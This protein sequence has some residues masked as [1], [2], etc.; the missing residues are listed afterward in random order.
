[1][2]TTVKKILK[3]CAGLVLLLPLAAL[4]AAPDC[5]PIKILPN[6]SLPQATVGDA[7]AASLSATEG[8]NPIAA[9]AFSVSRGVLPAGLSLSA[10]GVFSGAP[11][12]AGNT[13]VRFT[14][15]DTANGCSGQRTYVLH[16]V[17]LNHPPS[18]TKG[19]DQTAL[20]D[21]GAQTVTGWATAISDGDGGT[22]TLT[23][24]VTNNTNPGLFSA[25]P[26]VNA[27]GDL[28]YTPAPNA[29]GAATITLVLQDDGGT[30]N[31]GMD[32]SAPQTFTINVTAVNDAPSFTKGADQTVAENAPA[33]TI[34]NWAT[35]ISPGPA[36]ESGQSVSFQV[37]N[38]NNALFSLQ[39]AITPSGTLSFT[40]APNVSGSATVSVTLKDDGGT[41]N[42]G[43]DTSAAQ[44]F[45]ITVTPVNHAPSFTKGADQTVLEDAGGQTV[46]GWAT[47]ISDGDGG[48][49]TLT[50]NVTGNTNPGLFSAAPAVSA[51]GVLTYTPAAN[52]NGSATLTLV[53]Q[54]NGGTANGGVDTSAP[55]TFVINVT[56]VNDAPSFTAGP[57]QS[58]NEDAGARIVSNWATALS[59]GPADESA[60]TVSLQITGNSNPG[61]FAV[62]PAIDAAGTLTY[63]P[64]ANANGVA[65]V[66][67]VAKDNGGT[68]NGG[69][70]TSAPHT[71]VITVIPVNDAP[72]FSKGA[73]LT[74]ELD[75]AGPRTVTGWATAISPGPPDEAGQAVDFIVSNDNN[76]AFAV[77]PAIAANGTLTFTPAVQTAA[78]SKTANVTVQIHDNG[79]TANGGVD[80]SAAQ[81]FVIT[82]THANVAPTLGT[83]TI[84]YSTLGNTQLHVAGALRPGVANII[85]T[86]SI[87]AKSSPADSD[88]PSP[89]STVA[90]PSGSSANGGN[91]TI[92]TDGSF[93]YVPPVGF[94]GTD[95]FAFQ[96]TDGQDSV[97]GTVS[98]S[99]GSKVW[100]V[101]DLIDPDNPAGGDGRSSNAFE[102]LSA[103][104]SASAANDIIFVFRGNTGSTPLSA[105][106][107]LKNGQKLWGEGIGLTVAPFGTLVA[108]GSKP[109]VVTTGADTVSVAAT[110]GPMQNVEIRG[111][112]LA[113][114]GGT[115]NAVDVTASG[116]NAVG[117]TISDN[118]ISG[119]ALEGI[120]L[121]DGS[122]GTFVVSVANNTV[123]ST[124]NGIDARTSVAGANLQLAIDNNSNITAGSSGIVVDG[125]GGGSATITSFAGNTVHGNTVATGIAV[126]AARFDATPGGGFQTVSGG[127]TT[128][129]SAGN[130]VGGAGMV[131]TNVSGDISFTDLDV[132]AGG[133]D[134][135]QA[136]SSGTFN[137]GVGT[138]LQI[139][140]APNVGTIEA[141]G[142]AA[143]N[144]NTVTTDI[145]LASIKS[146]N[147]TT[148]G[149]NLNAVAGVLSAGSGSSISG[150]TAAATAFRVS[151]SNATVNYGGTISAT[152]GTG[153][154]LSG[155]TG[156]SI[157]FSGALTL[158]TGAN[159]AFTASGGGTVTATDTS[160]TL[161]TTTATALSV[162]NTT[163][164][165][166][167]LKFRSIS[168]GTAGSGPS[169]GIVLNN[170][171]AAGG[172]TV[173]GTGSAGSGGVI[174][175]A[176]APGISL[177]S[178]FGTSLSFMNVIN[179]TDDGINASSATNLSLTS[180]QVT[181]NGDSVTDEGLEL[182]NAGGTLTISNTSVTGS[183]HNNLFLDNASGTISAM[184]ISGSHFDN[185]SVAN[186]NHGALMQ[187]RGTSQLTAA[188]L[189]GNTFSGNRSIG[190]QVT[191]GDT[192]TVGTFTVQNNTFTNE[193]IALDFSKAQTSN[194][195][196]KFLSNTIT[197]QNSHGMNLFTAAGA[198]TTGVFNATVQGNT[199]GNQ[200]VASS[201]SAIGNCMRINVNGDADATVLVDNNT[202]RQCP[203]GR[204]I[205]A[206]GRNGTGG[207]DITITNNNV[208]PQDTSGF[209]L[210]AIFVQSN[211]L[212]V[213][214]K[215]RSDVRGNT[216]PT[217]TAFDLLSGYI[218]IVETGTST[219]ELVGSGATCAAQL[220]STNTGSTAASAGC[221]IIPGPISTPP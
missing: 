30:A 128:I 87:M 44:T 127:T 5:P 23:F 25:A 39:P 42:G 210:A 65:N 106:I 178:T 152:T 214:N 84:S 211:A 77:Q 165:A 33:Q 188:T 169:S 15:V 105:G 113:S 3:G 52:A 38:D 196:L 56:A 43:V 94:S 197:G 201:G 111:L 78:G 160:S 53:L 120:D 46:P 14:V 61:L 144:L 19:A 85:D 172:L 192:A 175:K 90:V 31:G 206:I 119:S 76:A 216:T 147:S 176:T 89:V 181:N 73:D 68:A 161:V 41:A 200:A 130:P 18:F 79:G 191:G 109:R 66:T 185:N 57:D 204:G 21:A 137:A 110:A 207:L 221:A 83:S 59:P 97:A 88:G 26:T 82:I 10:L 167:G 219:S 154:N 17:Q 20:E 174:Q 164:G 157:N 29:N 118:A 198:G 75:N 134:G 129:G 122:S 45:T 51:S 183:A 35:A 36:N 62:A 186:G 49:Q 194:M 60:Q 141:T 217:G 215:V 131:L 133:G 220:A 67:V 12:A 102:T 116:A 96:I 177:T 98:V 180:L 63:T 100:Y 155:N 149:V 135:L 64:A 95:T 104:Q 99:V 146:S 48:T 195:T 173:S 205:E 71:L 7:Y 108:A 32:T 47:A 28:S 92:N 34:P 132:Y 212:S 179:G 115:T 189:S 184:N 70:D 140:V 126:N 158:S 162:V 91:V 166:S 151:A 22:Q 24:A 54:D 124:G 209:P 199:I 218:Q 112:D 143:V 81:T 103:A 27:S 163:I 142:G 148:T 203:N 1:M 4:A 150:T 86:S 40:P 156:S 213:P 16:V 107:T 138:G 8:G 168:A 136:T 208:N 125:S 2:E 182:L 187:F 11:S 159:A 202:L 171:G 50:F 93:T 123:T 58:V 121:N 114:S 80:T 74:S 139:K 170:T 13:P 190:L 145:T 153:V 193:Q 55:Q 69:V 72:S 6:G 9:P 117:V 37:S 101:R